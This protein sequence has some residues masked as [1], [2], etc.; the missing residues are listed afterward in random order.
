MFH[1]IDGLMIFLVPEPLEAPVIVDAG[2]QKILV[3]GNQLIGQHLVEVGNDFGIS[4][5]RHYSSCSSLG[6]RSLELSREK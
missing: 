5:H 2:M 3:D 6:H 1:L 4:F